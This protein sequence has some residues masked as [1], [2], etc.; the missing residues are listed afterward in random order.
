[1]LILPSANHVFFQA[2]IPG[3]SDSGAKLDTAYIEFANGRKVE[4]VET[5]PDTLHLYFETLGST[6]DLDYMR[7]PIWS[8]TLGQ[9]KMGQPQLT[10]VVATDGNTGVHGKPFSSAAGS[11]VYAVTLAASRLHDREDI[12][13][14]RHHYDLEDQLEKPETGY[15][16]L[17]LDLL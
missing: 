15:V 2:I 16:M 17:T 7:L 4:H 14:A 3:S 10:L 9:S 13:V 5:N 6:G 11:C 1:M 8:H 12:F